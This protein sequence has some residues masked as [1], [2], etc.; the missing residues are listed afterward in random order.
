MSFIVL[1]AYFGTSIRSTV[2]KDRRFT[3]S[4]KTTSI[5][6]VVDAINQSYLLCGSEKLAYFGSLL[7][8]NARLDLF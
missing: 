4:D 1:V 7:C 2:S 6:V 3:I 8:S 5:Y